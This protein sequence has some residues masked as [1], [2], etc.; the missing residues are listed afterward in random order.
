MTNYLVN[1]FSEMLIEFSSGIAYLVQTKMDFNKKEFLFSKDAFYLN[2]PFE[3]AE[4]VIPFFESL[5]AKERNRIINLMQDSYGFQ[6][7]VDDLLGKFLVAL[8]YNL[9]LHSLVIAGLAGL[10]DSSIDT[11]V[12]LL[13]RFTSKEKSKVVVLT[14]TSSK[15]YGRIS[16]TAL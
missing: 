14:T 16:V 3:G 2:Y 7:R 12:E 1:V 15:L 13:K 5:K 10:G 9:E 4:K 8:F 6:V 11:C